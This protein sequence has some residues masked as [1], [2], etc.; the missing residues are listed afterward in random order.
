M[1]TRS[2]LLFVALLAFGGPAWTAEYNQVLPGQSRI[3]FVSKQMGVPVEGQFSRFTVRLA[4]DPARPEASHAAVDID[5]ASVDAGSR[6]ADNELMRP[7][8]FDVGKYPMA[9]FESTRVRSLGGNRYEVRGTMTLKGRTATVAAPF[10]FT[11][12]GRDGV[13]AGG[14]VL[15][16]LAWG[17][18]GGDWS[19]TDTV[20]NPVRIKF[21]FTASQ[22][23][24]KP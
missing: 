7:D 5:L 18:G 22:A 15:K 13:I 12:S 17:I 23:A 24:K 21:R 11:T 14:F 1:I 3:A 6:D 9:H 19:D 4:F 8:W 10:T 16:R 20:A 2:L